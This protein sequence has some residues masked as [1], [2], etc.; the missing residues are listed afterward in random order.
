MTTTIMS[1]N[2]SVLN[3]VLGQNYEKEL[4]VNSKTAKLKVYN[5]FKNVLPKT[6]IYNIMR[7]YDKRGT[8][9]RK[10][11]SGKKA[12]IMTKKNIWRLKREFENNDKIS[13]RNAARKYKC[14]Y[15]YIQKTLKKYSK[16][17]H[18]KKK[19]SPAYDETQIKMVRRKCRHLLCKYKDITF[20]I[21]DESYFPLSKSQVPGN[22]KFYTSD[23]STTPPD[24][25][26]KKKKK[27]E[28]K[29]L[30]YLV[31][32]EKGKS[33]IYIRKSKL[34]VTAKVYSEECLTKYLIPFVKE[35]RWT[36]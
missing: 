29:I 16:I 9:D 28:P 27:F 7:R 31:I 17:K 24:V 20:V 5:Q 22:D 15:T 6:T 36:L 19:R 30:L 4:S 8:T 25:K 10:V 14:H 3:K 11:G 32:S 13:L 1:I 23:I 2:K 18:R 12:K 26:Y 35:Y 34:A 21:D 33:R